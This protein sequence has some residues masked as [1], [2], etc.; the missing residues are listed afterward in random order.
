MLVR[1]YMTTNPRSVSSSDKASDAL[2]LMHDLK[3]SQMPVVDN[4][5]LVGIATEGELNSALGSMGP[6]TVDKVMIKDP[7]IIEEEASIENAADIIR[8]V[9]F[10]ILPVV[11]KD[12]RFTGIVSVSD[13]LDA[14][15]EMFSFAD[16]PIRLEVQMAPDLGLF[17]VL[18]LIEANSDKVLSFSSAPLDRSVCYFWVVD[19]DL[20]RVEKVLTEH[21]C[22]IT[23]VHS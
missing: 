11:N 2:K 19:C 4:G 14:L 7:V 12:G 23:V 10:N 13:I 8:N 5:R 21:K 9:D 16:K 20:G 17:D 18:H 6:V 15:R 3:Y 22:R 1:D